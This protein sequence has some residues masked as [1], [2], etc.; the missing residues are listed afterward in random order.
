MV[1][2]YEIPESVMALAWGKEK[3]AFGALV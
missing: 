3:Q 2:W 1:A